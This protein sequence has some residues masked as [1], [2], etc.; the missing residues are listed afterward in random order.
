MSV[1]L[2]FAFA[3]SLDPSTGPFADLLLALE[4]SGLRG[5]KPVFTDDYRGLF[6]AMM[7]GRADVAWCPPLVALDLERMDATNAIAAVTHKGRTHRHTALLAHPSSEIRRL[8]DL[9]R[10]RI[11]WVSRESATGYVAARE[12]L[13]SS[14]VDLAFESEVFFDTHALL[15]RAL[16]GGRVDVIA[17]H[18]EVEGGAVQLPHELRFARV[19]GAKGPIPND[20]VVAARGLGP[21]RIRAV[22]EALFATRLPTHG[23]LA[24]MMLASGFAALP[25]NHFRSLAYS[26]E[27]SCSEQSFASSSARNAS[28]ISSRRSSTELASVTTSNDALRSSDAFA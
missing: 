28:R 5:V 14:G 10:A 26:A 19:L 22:K 7:L 8:T 13:A 18:A 15:G 1:P 27:R 25:K 3:T 11:G 4:R 20:V 2:R 23:S 24:K 16:R 9:A 6:E 17:T 12:Y 21:E